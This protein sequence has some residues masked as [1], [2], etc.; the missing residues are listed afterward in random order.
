MFL[1]FFAILSSNLEAEQLP[2]MR[3]GFRFMEPPS[4]II[5]KL[6]KQIVANLGEDLSNRI[7][8]VLIYEFMLEV[9]IADPLL[10]AKRIAD[11]AMWIDQLNPN[12]PTEMREDPIF[13]EILKRTSV[14][15]PKI[16]DVYQS[17]QVNH[18]SSMFRTR[19]LM[20]EPKERNNLVAEL[21]DLSV[22]IGASAIQMNHSSY[23]DS[24]RLV[25][26]ISETLERLKK[27]VN[28]FEK[29]GMEKK[30]LDKVFIAQVVYGTEQITADI[31][32]G[33]KD[34]VQSYLKWLVPYVE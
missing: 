34:K 4:P 28:V 13:L 19:Q 7:P 8:Y 29:S 12:S 21:L 24:A 5:N 18:N 3:T 20:D 6:D 9:E 33:L 23:D 16:G 1:P 32:L 30:F 22:R 26:D 10:Q 31:G 15:A 17:V 2:K 25:K 14:Y 11:L 27:L